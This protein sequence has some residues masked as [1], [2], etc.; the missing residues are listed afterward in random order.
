[1]LPD[2]AAGGIVAV[3]PDIVPPVATAFQV[4]VELPLFE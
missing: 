3:V 1:M 4:V 2:R